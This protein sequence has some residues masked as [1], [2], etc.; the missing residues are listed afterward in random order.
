MWDVVDVAKQGKKADSLKLSAGSAAPSPGTSGSGTDASAATAA[1]AAE[2]EL[3]AS[4]VDVMRG[5]HAVIVCYDPRKRWTWDYVE[6]EV[7]KL[8]ASQVHVLVLENFRDA[9]LDPATASPQDSNRR[10]ISED[11]ARQFCEMNG[12]QISFAQA[13]PK[14]CYGLKAVKTFLNLPFLMVQ[15]Q[16][17]EAK[18]RR[19]QED[20]AQTLEEF[21]IVSEEQPYD[22]Y[23]TFLSNRTKAVP[24]APES[25][26]A[27]AVPESRVPADTIRRS[28]SGLATANTEASSSPRISMATATAQSSAPKRT[29]ASEPSKPRTAAELEKE[30]AADAAALVEQIRREQG[31]PP[32]VKKEEKKGFFSSLFS[33]IS[34][35][36]PKDAP[37]PTTVPKKPQAAEDA[38]SAIKRLGSKGI[39]R[40]PTSVDDFVPEADDHDDWLSGPDISFGAGKSANKPV[41]SDDEDEGNP[42]VAA[43]SDVEPVALAQ[44]SRRVVPQTSAVT[45]PK[46]PVAPPKQPTHMPTP[47]PAPPP[48]LQH[49]AEPS[50]TPKSTPVSIPAKA[51]KLAPSAPP[52]SAASYSPITSPATKSPPLGS[53]VSFVESPSS[54]QSS[55]AVESPD[56]SSPPD[57]VQFGSPNAIPFLESPAG[58]ESFF[59]DESVP[60][61]A[62]SANSE[63]LRASDSEDDTP[64]A[65]IVVDDTEPETEPEIVTIVA[66]AARRTRGARPAAPPA[67]AAKKSRSMKDS[68][69]LKALAASMAAD[70]DIAV[71][72]MPAS[73]P[74]ATDSPKPDLDSK[75]KAPSRSSSGRTSSRGARRDSSLSGQGVVAADSSVD[76]DSASPMHGQEKHGRTSTPSGDTQYESF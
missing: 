40:G 25:A 75:D 61:I 35:D 64:A 52:P 34:S 55:T 69:A 36:E 13:S 47:G 4:T 17:L 67:P 12:A 54:D 15:K 41:D 50:E 5:A 62:S 10:Q 2:F 23:L 3:D 22:S 1:A 20:T 49:V 59:E 39:S 60:S 43:D 63:K 7:P 6:K 37:S 9:V 74:K 26:A 68:E 53:P 32:A 28:G 19:N 71:D 42:M 57:S 46:P 31:L 58:L 76:R 30:A 14:N 18:L 21:R 24:N 70:W 48:V 56:T 73:P 72:S 33:K 44:T 27:A 65:K 45:V 11:E 8:A 51:P 29:A 16:S 66:P 38:V